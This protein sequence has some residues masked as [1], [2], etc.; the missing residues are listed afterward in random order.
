MF[1]YFSKI[2]YNFG[3]TGGTAQVMD[4][5]KSVNVNLDDDL[6]LIKQN[7]TVKERPD[8]MSNRIYGFFDYYWILLLVNGIKNPLMNWSSLKSLYNL[9]IGNA[10]LFKKKLE[11]NKN[12]STKINLS[13][14]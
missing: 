14:L 3:P 7:N 8:Q 1:Q 11:N 6:K 4:I 10:N 2:N 12:R 9:S 5:F 13:E